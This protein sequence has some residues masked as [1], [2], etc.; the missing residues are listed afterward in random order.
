MGQS[1]SALCIPDEL[2]SAVVTDIGTVAGYR[3]LRSS[4]SFRVLV[5]L[6]SLI[7]VRRGEKRLHVGDGTQRIGEDH[8]LLMLPGLQTMS[9]VTAGADGYQSTIVSFTDAFLAEMATR[10]LKV[11][12]GS[13]ETTGTVASAQA[14]PYLREVLR[15][16]PLSLE[17]AP[18]PRG[19]EPKLTELCMALWESPLRGTLAVAIERAMTS[20]DQ[21]LRRVVDCHRFESLTVAQLAALSARSLSTF[22]RDFQRI[23]GEAPGAWLRRTRLERARMML[24]STN[25][26][27]TRVATESGFADTSAFIRAFRRA[28]GTTPK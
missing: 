23:Y 4:Q 14:T 5:R 8:V 27:V 13:Q 12:N 18:G 10:Y 15:G 21:R 25:M 6:T 28:F 3:V 11:E 9:E 19:L 22:K 7:F 1:T 26:P 17:Y 20:G 16:L 2:P 24:A